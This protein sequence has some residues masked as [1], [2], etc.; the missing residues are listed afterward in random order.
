[1]HY[2][3]R[4]LYRLLT[5]ECPSCVC[6]FLPDMVDVDREGGVLKHVPGTDIPEFLV[7][8]VS[9]SGAFICFFARSS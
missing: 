1:M 8:W 7:L 2:C 9:L 6:V 4:W 5:I 3:A